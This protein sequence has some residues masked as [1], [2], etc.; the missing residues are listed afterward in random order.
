MSVTAQTSWANDP[1][2]L[3]ASQKERL[4]II[5]MD[6][7]TWNLLDPMMER[8]ELPNFKALVDQ[9]QGTLLESERPIRSPALW[10]TI[11]TGQPRSTHGIYD[12]VTGTNYWPKELRSKSAD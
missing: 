4:V 3:H 7:L 2:A 12:F 5:G 6:G 10:T 1:E 11:A 8:G 9:G